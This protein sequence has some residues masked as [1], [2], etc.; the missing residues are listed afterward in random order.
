MDFS[1][2]IQRCVKID[3][4]IFLCCNIDILKLLR[5][6]VKVVLCYFCHLPNKT[7][8]KL[9]QDFKLVEDSALK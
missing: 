3:T 9:D 6:F 8:L 5:G 1:K 4:W 2:L 7:K